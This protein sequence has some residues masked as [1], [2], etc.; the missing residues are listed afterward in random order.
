MGAR[1]FVVALDQRTICGATD[2]L[3]CHQ[4]GEEFVSFGERQY[5]VCKKCRFFWIPQGVKLADS[6]KTIYEDEAPIF[7]ADGNTAYYLD[8]S[9]LRSASLKCEWVK[10]FLPPG[11]RLLDVGSN[12]GHFLSCASPHFVADGIEPSPVAVEWAERHF[13]VSSCVGSVYELKDLGRKPYAAITL[14]DVI[15]HVDDPIGALTQLREALEPNGLLFISTPDSDSWCARA[16]GKSW[17]YLDPIQ[18][19]A[20]FGRASLCALLETLGFDVLGVR[21]FGHHYRVGYV[22]DRLLA[23]RDASAMRIPL[24]LLRGVLWPVRD[25]SVYISLGDVMGVVARKREGS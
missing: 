2:C 11:A 13:G 25:L 16:L 23:L 14:W 22:C 4:Q 1:G 6:G 19:V 17:H 18:H 24:R 21:T 10:I 3:L 12:F 7:F 5:L 15:E 9:N 8:S 20:V